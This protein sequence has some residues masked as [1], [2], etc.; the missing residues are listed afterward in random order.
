MA[1]PAYRA[2]SEDTDVDV[3][4]FLVDLWRRAPAW[5]KAEM[6]TRLCRAAEDLA[7]VGLRSR[8]PSAPLE[9]IR[10]RL[11]SLRLDRETMIEVYDWDPLLRGTG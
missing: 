6:V 2:Q 3:D 9:E 7:L 4:R 5:K 10:L 8:H 1:S 11:A